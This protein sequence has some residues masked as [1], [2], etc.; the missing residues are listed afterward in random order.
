MSD[1]I[2]TLYYK[3]DGSKDKFGKIIAYVVMGVQGM[4]N[5][6]NVTQVTT[7]IFSSRL[8]VYVPAPGR[9]A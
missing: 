4:M 5:I 2:F 1:E 3:P 9:Q 6:R 7:T 8:S